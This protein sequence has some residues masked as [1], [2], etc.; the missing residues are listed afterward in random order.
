[1]TLF[2]RLIKTLN[3]NKVV[4]RSELYGKMGITPRG[5]NYYTSV[6][7]Q[8]G[9][10]FS[11]KEFLVLNKEMPNRTIDFFKKTKVDNEEVLNQKLKS[12]EDL[13]LSHFLTTSEQIMFQK[14]KGNI[15]FDIN[16]FAQLTNKNKAGISGIF[17]K[18]VQTGYMQQ[19][20]DEFILI[21]DIPTWINVMKL[22]DREIK[23]KEKEIEEDRS[24]DTTW[25]YK[26][27]NTF[28]QINTPE[29][30]KLLLTTLLQAALW[31]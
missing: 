4:N 28:P 13:N 16:K 27:A 23:T 1:M 14:M 5:M 3:E 30:K 8:A 26:Y 19:N 31:K 11:F 10:L 20:G 15:V 21:A 12:A 22:T 9:Y 6:L 2:S 18:L 7:Q 25:V 29:E 24:I 17:N